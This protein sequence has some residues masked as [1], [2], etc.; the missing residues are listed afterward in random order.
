MWRDHG[1]KVKGAD[2]TWMAIIGPDTP[3]TGE[4]SEKGQIFNSQ[5]AM[6]IASLLE[7]DYKNPKAGSSLMK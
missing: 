4:V 7:I 3:A 6:T 2:Q 1:S 5:I